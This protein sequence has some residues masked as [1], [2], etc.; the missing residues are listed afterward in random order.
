MPS[1][2]RSTTTSISPKWSWFVTTKPGK[3]SFDESSTTYIIRVVN[4]LNVC[5][6]FDKMFVYICLFKISEHG[7]YYLFVWLNDEHEHWCYSFIYVCICLFTFVHL[8][9]FIYVQLYIFGYVC[10]C[11]F[12]Y[13]I[14]HTSFC[15]QKYCKGCLFFLFIIVYGHFVF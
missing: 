9:S 14:S 3:S 11:S 1:R 6:S 2:R 8:C 15:F 4:E 5:G 13:V 10:L 12:V 7:Q